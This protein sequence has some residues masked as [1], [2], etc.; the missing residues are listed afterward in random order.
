MED[1]GQFYMIPMHR[2]CPATPHLRPSS[3]SHRSG[4]TTSVHEFDSPPS[5]ARARSS[6]HEIMREKQS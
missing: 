5:A 2:D 4:A 6:P 1:L 3:R